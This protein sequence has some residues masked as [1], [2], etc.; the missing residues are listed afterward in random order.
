MFR[1]VAEQIF[2]KAGAREIKSADGIS[3]AIVRYPDFSKQ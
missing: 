2:T 1:G 3:A